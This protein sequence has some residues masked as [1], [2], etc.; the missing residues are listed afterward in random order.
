MFFLIS[1][2][3]VDVLTF[4]TLAVSRIP[5]EVRFFQPAERTFYR[6]IKLDNNFDRLDRYVFCNC[7]IEGDVDGISE[8]RPVGSAGIFPFVNQKCSDFL[9][10]FD[11]EIVGEIS[12]DRYEE[13]DRNCRASE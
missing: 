13:G 3:T 6:K 12:I 2:I 10:K 11:A 1:L 5:V 7:W 4:N 8:V 9:G